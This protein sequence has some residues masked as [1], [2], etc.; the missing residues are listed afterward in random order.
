[1]CSAIFVFFPGEKGSK[2][3]SDCVDM[4]Y[5]KCYTK[6]GFKDSGNVLIC[7]PGEDCEVYGM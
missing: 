1:M 5:V 3:R 6:E 4:L 2:L 7:L